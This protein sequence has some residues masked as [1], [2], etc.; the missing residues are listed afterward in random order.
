MRTFSVA[1]WGLP[2][3]SISTLFKGVVT[4][5][6][7]KPS[8]IPSASPFLVLNPPLSWSDSRKPPVIAHQ[9]F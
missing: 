2:V 5:Q 8:R 7:V 3:S 9:G 4:V 1:G 6:G